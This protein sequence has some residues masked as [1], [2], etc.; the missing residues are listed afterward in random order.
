M[1]TPAAGQGNSPLILNRHGGSRYFPQGS[2]DHRVTLSK[3]VKEEET[4]PTSRSSHRL[5]QHK[6]DRATVKLRED[7]E[8]ERDRLYALTDSV[9]KDHK[10]RETDRA[11]DRIDYALAQLQVEQDVRLLVEELVTSLKEISQLST[12]VSSL[13]IQRER[14]RKNLMEIIERGRYLHRWEK[15]RTDSMGGDSPR[16]T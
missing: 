3:D 11:K 2:V 8:H 9:L 10:Y 14:E 16:R 15:T 1:D 4:P 6:M 5:D 7:L 13:R 12:E